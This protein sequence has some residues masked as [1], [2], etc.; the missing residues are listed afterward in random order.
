MSYSVTLISGDGIGEEITRAMQQVLDA[1][2]VKIS[3]DKQMAGLK[4]VQ[5]LG[6]ALPEATLESIRNNQVAIKGPTTTPVG[7]GH[8][9]ANVLLR[10]SLDLY[11]AVRPVKSIPGV[12]TRYEQ[13]DLV[14][15]RENTEG[16]YTGQETQV[17]PDTVVSLKIVT[18][19]GSRRIAKFALELCE[20][21]N[22]KN[23]TVGH[24]ANIIKLGDGLFLRTAY[25]EAS[26]HP[27]VH[28]RDCIVDALCMK[29]VTAPENFDVL[30]LENLY[31]DI[32][33]D[34]CAGLVGGLGLVPGA[35][36]GD[37][38]AVFESVHGSA[39]DIAGQ[40]KANPTALIKSAVMMLD[41]LGEKEASENI[42]AALNQIL[43]QK[44]LRTA[45]LG[46]VSTTE[47]FTQS[48]IKALV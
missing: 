38:Q 41:Y 28:T 31:G 39:P 8:Q 44:K 2:G 14:I 26:Q 12:K 6:S 32:L 10:Q 17:K 24:K 34:L 48:V 45:D 43:S 19:Q 27:K 47:E 18:E 29:L 40:N 46:G 9:S 16:L 7:T 5:T 4:A 15:V 36:F 11:A 13:V 30:L 33:S 35:N 21:Q 20:K 37:K 42:D 25:E 23:L 3:W 22:R 1:S